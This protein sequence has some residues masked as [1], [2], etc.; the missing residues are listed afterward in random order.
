MSA[1]QYNVEFTG[2][3]A[4]EFRKMDGSAQRRIAAAIQGLRANPRP[5]GVKKL[6][7]YDTAY[8]IRVGDYCVIYEVLDD[9]LL[10]EVFRIRNRRDAYKGM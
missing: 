9:V 4:K 5:S 8:R 3:A 6:V 10:V 1:Q 2:D 7:G